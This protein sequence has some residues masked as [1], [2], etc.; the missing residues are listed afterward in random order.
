MSSP[1]N[2]T[3]TYAEPRLKP[4]NPSGIEVPTS[5]DASAVNPDNIGAPGE[6]LFTRG[7]FPDGWRWKPS[8]QC[9][10]GL[11]SIFTCA[12]DE[13]FQITTESPIYPEHTRCVRPQ[14]NQPA[15]SI[16][17]CRFAAHQFRMYGCNLYL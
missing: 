10:A 15:D 13:A 4:L 16:R 1:D 5:V 17:N 3:T 14:G 7:S 9:S 6:Y 11:Q 12:F 8:P 2:S